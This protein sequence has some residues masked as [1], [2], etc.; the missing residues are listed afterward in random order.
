M[1]SKFLTRLKTLKSSERGA[2][3]IYFA[4][5]IPMFM[6]FGG[7]A[8]DTAM[9]LSERRNLQHTVDS[10]AIA[11]AYALK[12]DDQ[13]TNTELVADAKVDAS[14]NSFTTGGS[15]TLVVQHPPTAGS[16]VGNTNVV[17]VELASSVDG[18]FSQFFGYDDLTVKTVASAGVFTTSQGSGCVIGLNGSEAQTIDMTGNTGVDLT[19]GISSNSTHAYGL[20]IG[21]S[22]NVTASA[23]NANG[24]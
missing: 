20:S 5:A 13:S 2:I 23:V 19:C 24:V 14:Y 7:L 15:N 3:A 9:W 8:L 10:A 22:A 17:R 1:L 11:A 21:G 12:V 6:G 18:F 16:F 4:V